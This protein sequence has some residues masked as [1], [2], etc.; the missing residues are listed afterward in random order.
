M[1]AALLQRPTFVKQSRELYAYSLV[2]TPNDTNILTSG[3]VTCRLL[4]YVVNNFG[5][6]K[7]K[8]FRL[9]TVIIKNI[10]DLLMNDDSARAESVYNY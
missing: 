4:Q 1:H 7:T 9:L 2:E 8:V 6:T 10:G 5:E 3:I